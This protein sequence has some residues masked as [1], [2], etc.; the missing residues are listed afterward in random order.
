M[1]LALFFSNFDSTLSLLQAVLILLFTQ[2]VKAGWNLNATWKQIVSWII[3]LALTFL[4][5]IFQ[6]GMFANME[7]YFVLTYSLGFGL[8]VNGLYDSKEVVISFVE[9]IINLIN[10]LRK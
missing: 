8:L 10:K 5:N 9:S 2:V 7:W 6:L 1:D 3:C 4:A